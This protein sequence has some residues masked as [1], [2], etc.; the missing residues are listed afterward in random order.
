[1]KFLFVTKLK[2][3]KAICN[4]PSKIRKCILLTVLNCDMVYRLL[5][6]SDIKKFS[7]LPRKHIH[8]II[9]L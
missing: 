6:Y 1:M 7:C 9:T 5:L 8:T 4:L 2:Q 3:Y